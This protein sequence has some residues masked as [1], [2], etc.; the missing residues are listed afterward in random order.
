MIR[1]LDGYAIQVDSYCYTLGVAKNTTVVDKK[2][3]E[4]V[5]KEILVDCKYYPDLDK[6]LLGYWKIMRRKKLANFEGSLQ[7]AL[8]V[9][10]K[11]DERIIKLISKLK[12]EYK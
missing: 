1:L 7:D 6:T 10:K 3:G 5:T 12:E 4:E 2:T 9:V 8:E 11:L